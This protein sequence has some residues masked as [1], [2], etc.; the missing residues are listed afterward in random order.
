MTKK[1]E[2]GGWTGTAATWGGSEG[3][4][5]LVGRR[6]KNPLSTDSLRQTCLLLSGRKLLGI[7]GKSQGLRRLN[8]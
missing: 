4:E 7:E 1:T 2:A 6:V 3:A 5:C 8:N